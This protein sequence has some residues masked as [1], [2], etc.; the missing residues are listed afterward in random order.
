MEKPL[1]AV[2]GR[3]NVG[4]STLFNRV[5]GRRIAIVED[6]PGITR[7]RLYAEAAWNGKEFVLIDTGGILMN[8]GDPLKAQVTAQAEVAL[9]EADVIVF[10]TDVTTGVTSSDLDIAR[11]LRSAKKPVLVAANKADNLDGDT[12]SA[13]FYEFGIGEVYPVSSLNGRSVADLLDAIVEALPEEGSRNAYPEDAVKIAVIGRPNVG[14]SSLINAIIGDKRVIV[15]DIAG[16]TRDAID[17][18]VEHKGEESVL[19]DTAGIRRSGKVQGSV[20]Y[21]TVLRAL[22]AMERADVAVIVID[23]ADGLRDGD[24]RVAGFAKDAGRAC[25]IAVNKWDLCDEE[26]MKEFA[27]NIRRQLPYIDYA[28]IVFTSALTGMGVTHV[29][30]TARDAAASHAMRLPTSEIN[31]I[32]LNAAEDHPYTR[33]GRELKIKFASMA[34]VKPPTVVVFVNDTE[35]VHFSYMR[36]LENQIR[37]YYSYEG[38]PIK[39]IFKRAKKERGGS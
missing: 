34:E 37:M 3:P 22:R 12:D 28:P 14:K 21:Y 25:V 9:D 7:D 11:K 29:L 39:L 32:I 8:E 26:V 5:V 23:G 38:T 18:V 17:T 35:L 13:V 2:V 30:E 19:I 24:K 36:Y 33:K 20:E 31:R 10:M 15:S 6:E 16:T 4:K 27:D 1:V